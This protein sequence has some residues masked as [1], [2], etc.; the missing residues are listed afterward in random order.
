MVTI[1][2]Y[3]WHISKK[4]NMYTKNGILALKYELGELTFFFSN[5]HFYGKWILNKLLLTFFEFLKNYIVKFDTKNTATQYTPYHRLAT[6][7]SMHLYVTELSFDAIYSAKVKSIPVATKN[8]VLVRQSN[9]V[10][11]KFCSQLQQKEFRPRTINFNLDFFLL[12]P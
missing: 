6:K 3:I 10:K 5:I 1:L 4:K 9:L 12:S 8:C 11:L 7:I 2:W